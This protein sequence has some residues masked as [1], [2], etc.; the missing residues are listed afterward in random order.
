MLLLTTVIACAIAL[1]INLYEEQR[2]YRESDF[3]RTFDAKSVLKTILAD[4]DVS[5]SI[6]ATGG[7]LAQGHYGGTYRIA[8]P[9][10]N[11]YAIAKALH[12]ALV[13]SLQEKKLAVT[14]GQSWIDNMGM[15]DFCLIYRDG[16]AVGSIYVYVWP[17]SDEQL[18]IH[19][20]VHEHK[21]D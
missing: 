10:S 4:S 9:K 16:Q 18:V 7:S 21:A 5:N 1:C 13:Q 14:R 15:R 11:Q 19:V 8:T 12:A 2:P 17:A 6:A 20:F 3:L